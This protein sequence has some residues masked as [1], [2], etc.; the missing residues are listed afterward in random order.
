MLKIFCSYAKEDRDAVLPFYEK[1]K[2]Y[3]FSPWIDCNDIRPGQNWDG[4]IDRALKEANVIILFISPRSATKR[5]FVQRE[6]NEAI[7]LLQYKLDDDIFIIPIVLEKCEIPEKIGEKLQYIE[8]AH[9]ESDKRIRE[10]L[11]IAARQQRIII[12]KG[13]S[14]GQFQLFTETLS[15]SA[16]GKP[17]YDVRIVYPH[18]T[19]EKFPRS[20]EHLNAIFLGR[21]TEALA[22]ERLG[23]W[24]ESI[25]WPYEN[26]I[27]NGRWDALAVVSTSNYII[28]VCYDVG[29]YGA[30]AAHSN[31]HFETYNFIISDD[32]RVFKIDPKDIFTAF[33][34]AKPK[35]IELCETS[36]LEQLWKAGN[37]ADDGQKN[38]IKQGLEDHSFDQCII[39]PTGL[40]YYFAPY[41]V[42]A[43]AYG[44]FTVHIPYFHIR[45]YF[46]K[47]GIYKLVNE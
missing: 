14:V 42:A 47:N 2:A 29:W 35:I 12:N 44:N 19:S 38:W 45:E 10:S 17:G 28:S 25:D 33:I 20:A 8:A 22:R 7:N 24:A 16:E 37:E 5:G 34:D 4:A 30:G 41:E 1:F 40:Y 3:G 46:N 31:N 18:F 43:Y 32:D 23:P 9:P 39:A 13:E 21:A 11:D 26:A 6:F 15:E 36:I 27:S